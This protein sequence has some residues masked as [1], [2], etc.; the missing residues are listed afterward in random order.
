MIMASRKAKEEALYEQL[1]RLGQRLYIPIPEA[2]WDI[3]VQ[4][5]NGKVIQRLKQRSHSWVRN[6]Y[7]MMFCYLAGKDLDNGAFGA[8]YLSLRD[9]G[10]SVQYGSG[11]VCLGRAVSTDTTQ[12]GYRGPAGNDDYGILVGSGTNPEDFESYALQSKIAKGTGAGQLTYVESEAHAVTWTP[13]TLTMKNALARYF[14]NNSGGQVDVNEVALALRGYRPG[15][16]VPYN[17]MTARDNL[18]SIVSVPDTGQL[19]VT[20]TVQLTYPA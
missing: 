14:N 9:T 15:S 4:N 20:Y 19:K 10:G 7:N 5:S 6:A 17:Y 11:P 2:F 16:S 8:G 13:G 1:R 18:A 3:E 12:W